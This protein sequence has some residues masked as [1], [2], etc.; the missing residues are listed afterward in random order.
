MVSTREENLT[1]AR[2]HLAV[3]P[4]WS[5]ARIRSAM[6]RA[7]VFENMPTITVAMSFAVSVGRKRSPS[8]R[9]ASSA[10]RR[11]FSSFK[12]T[13]YWRSRSAG[14]IW[15]PS[16]GGVGLRKTG[17]RLRIVVGDA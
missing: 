3:P 9:W 11:W 13:N 7:L 2:R 16:L 15:L 12:R 4:R 6:S 8:S 1:D 17:Q 14:V 10:C 5:F